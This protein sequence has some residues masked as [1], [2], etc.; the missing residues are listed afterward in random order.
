MTTA[1]QQFESLSKR[2]L[3]GMMALNPISATRHGDYSEAG[4]ERRL[5]FTKATLADLATIPA[6]QLSRENQVDAGLLSNE[7]RGTVFSMDTLQE[8]KTDPLL[9]NRLAGDALYNL[10]ARDFAPMQERLRAAMS[11]MQ[12]LPQLLARARANLDPKRVP[13]IAA[14]TVAKQNHGIVSV[15]DDLISAHV[16]ELPNAEQVQ[17][18]QAISGLR[19]AV[20]DHQTWID[21]TLVPNATGNFRLSEQQYDQKLALSLDSSLSRKEI[22]QRAERELQRVRANM[23]QL[24]VGLLKG[25]PNAPELPAQP[26]DAQ[27]QKAIETALELAYKDRPARDQVVAVAKQTLAQATTFVREHDLVAVPDD[28]VKVILMPEF[29]RGVAVAYCDSPGPLD[30]GLDTYYAISP[31]PDDWTDAQSDSFLREYNTRMM[32]LL[33]IHEAMPGHYL[34]GVHSAKHPSLLR[35][36]LRSGLFAEGWAVYT[37]QLL[38]AE[39]Y[40]DSDPLFRLVQGKFYLRAIANAILDQGVHVDGWNREQAMDLMVRQTFQQER[41]AAGKWVRAQLTSAQLPTYFV[42]VQEQWDL[43][44]DVQAKE[45]AAFNLKNYHNKVLSYGAP[46]TRYVRALMMNEAIEIRN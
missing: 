8:W 29:Q 7:L 18:T 5:A 11:R 31:I 3:D 12:K 37:E 10:M 30:K 13:R 22:R 15:V 42:G 40:L 17:I 45:G 6:S 35:A 24:S 16:S 28:P 36:V 1:D 44:H 32:H 9:Y 2:W 26:S 20:A 19:Q 38:T 21:K 46:P 43:R 4:N 27:Q 14:E 39:G 41:E 33:S 23:Y 34:E 25:K